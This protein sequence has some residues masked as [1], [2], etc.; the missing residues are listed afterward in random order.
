[1]SLDGS[2]TEVRVTNLMKNDD[3]YFAVSN[4]TLPQTLQLCTLPVSHPGREG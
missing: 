2:S 3:E 4:K 1:M